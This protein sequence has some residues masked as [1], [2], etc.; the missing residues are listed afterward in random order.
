[1]TIS[2][3][4]AGAV[5]IATALVMAG[6]F[7]Q[8]AWAFTEEELRQINGPVALNIAGPGQD[9]ADLLSSRDLELYVGAEE[10]GGTGIRL[11]NFYTSNLIDKSQP[12][13]IGRFRFRF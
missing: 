8:S 13:Q 1:M 3:L 5:L 10:P 6:I 2:N 4:Y 11:D 12:A 7:G 9:N